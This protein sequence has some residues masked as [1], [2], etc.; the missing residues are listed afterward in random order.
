MTLEDR[1]RR[2]LSG[3]EPSEALK[4]RIQ[5]RIRHEI[6]PHE[7]LLRDALRESMPS[8]SVKLSVWKR[9]FGS[10][11]GFGA[12]G[13]LTKLSDLLSPRQSQ[14]QR[15]RASLFSRV[16]PAPR[17]S[18]GSLKWVA[19]WVIVLVVLRFSPAF[20]LTE[21]GSAESSVLL[22]PTAG[23]SSIALHGL[24][25][26]L[27]TETT[28]VQA[29][30]LQTHENGELTVLLHDDGTIRLDGGS[31]VQLLDVTNRPEP[32]STES[33]LLV[34]EGRVW[35]QGLVPSHLRGIRI[36]TPDGFI[37]LYEGS[38][39]VTVQDGRTTVRVWSGRATV[40][41]G[42]EEVALVSGEQLE[43]SIPVLSIHSLPS[44]SYEETWVAQNLDR[45]AVHRREIAQ[46]QQE[47]RSARAGILPTSPLY[48][49][50]RV[51][52]QVDLL[53]T[54]NEEERVQKQLA[55][56]S[57]RLDEA[58]TLIASGG[59]DDR[60]ESVLN[61][62]RDN[63]LT[64]AN[65]TGSTSVMQFLLSQQLAENTSDIGIA[66]ADDALYSVKK[67]VLE[68]SAELPTPGVNPA[69]VK[70]VLLVDALHGIQENVKNGDLVT[71]Q[72]SLTSLDP[73]LSTLRASDTVYSQGTRKEAMTI[74]QDVV[75]KLKEGG[76]ETG[77][78]LVTA[79]S[80]FLPAP[81]V[82]SV[83]VTTPSIEPLTDE[84]IAAM[85]DRILRRID[86]YEHP[87]SRYNQLV[88]EL[89]QLEGHNDE[90]RILRALSV[91]LEGS[92]ERDAIRDRLRS[93]RN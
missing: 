52:E 17:A 31:T 79:V 93:L 16:Q 7:Q 9:I 81:T 40:T 53:L 13:I 78:T 74:L 63:V 14:R 20:V 21:R 86:T 76:S 42:E 38:T 41:R 70:G 12:A 25:Q 54:F 60:V 23:Q 66:T 71:A 8:Q 5:A 34:Q 55:Q 30:R 73:Y 46:L 45:D 72:T 10:I 18:F 84:Q 90:G 57:T 3:I 22:M 77:A 69:E 6:A 24:W 88:Q 33:T 48:P 11:E 27:T 62:Y 15:M 87:R 51:A 44:R 4:K 1:L 85:I 58:A 36:D 32:S 35:V 89:R 82:P 64:V 59:E 92:L 65:S 43:L 61:E 50:K 83:S 68:V 28:I 37:S 67:V 39:D 56:A 80:E 26:P 91:Q 19:A 2:Q 47:R 75:A 49:V 29:S